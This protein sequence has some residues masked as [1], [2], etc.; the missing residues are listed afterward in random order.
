MVQA[1]ELQLGFAVVN[2]KASLAVKRRL[3]CEQVEVWEE[4]RFKSSKQYTLIHIDRQCIVGI[5]FGKYCIPKRSSKLL[6]IPCWAFNLMNGV[7]MTGNA[8]AGF[9]SFGRIIEG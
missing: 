4:V 6:D 1:V 8:K 2:V 7:C 9:R 3:A 5:F